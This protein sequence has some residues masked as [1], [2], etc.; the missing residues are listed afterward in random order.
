ME[1]QHAALDK[2][3]KLLTDFCGNSPRGNVTPWW[4]NS[5]EGA[6][7]MLKYGIEYGVFNGLVG[8]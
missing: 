8:D 3:F 7:L 1:Q 5:K 2:S 4:E 6:E